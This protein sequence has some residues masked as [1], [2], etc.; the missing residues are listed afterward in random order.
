VAV[1][2]SAAEGAAKLIAVTNA[3]RAII[4]VSLGSIHDQSVEPKLQKA[5]AARRPR[6]Q[7]YS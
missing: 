3:M 7:I 5:A 1:N 2:A 4:S 6:Q